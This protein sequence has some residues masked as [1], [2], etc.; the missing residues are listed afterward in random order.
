ML[1]LLLL[2]LMMMMMMMMMQSLMEVT[3]SGVVCATCRA[4]NSTDTDYC[5]ACGI[6]L[7]S[8]PM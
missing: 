1:L 7:H 4:I 8:T 6:E 2:L 3:G 5:L